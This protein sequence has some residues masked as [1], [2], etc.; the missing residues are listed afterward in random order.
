MATQKIPGRAIKLGTDNAPDTIGDVAY[1]DGAAWKRLAIGIPGQQLTMNQAGTLPH[2]G[3][4]FGGDQFGYCHGGTDEPNLSVYTDTIDKFSFA[5]DSD[6]TDVGNLTEPM[7]ACSGQSSET[8]GYRSG[9][10]TNYPSVIG[11]NVIDKFAFGSSSNSTD[12]G[13][14]SWQIGHTAG[15]SSLTDG[16]ICGGDNGAISGQG[17]IYNGRTDNIDSFSFAS[18]VI[19]LREQLLSTHRWGLSGQQV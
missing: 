4:C 6:A 9:G 18:D 11:S 13:D 1:F 3:Y 17:Y 5:A 7:N 10:G 19:A 14:M 2:W 12:V 16:Y 15:V 8:H